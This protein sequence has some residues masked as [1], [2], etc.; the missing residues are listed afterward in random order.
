MANFVFVSSV[1]G[2]V[3]TLVEF[4]FPGYL[5]G[6]L[7]DTVAYHYTRVIIFYVPFFVVQWMNAFPVVSIDQ[8]FL[9]THASVVII[10]AALV[11]IIVYLQLPS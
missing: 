4:A 5:L 8:P 11:S 3:A 7:Y 6:S 9:L 10:M 2:L 1:A